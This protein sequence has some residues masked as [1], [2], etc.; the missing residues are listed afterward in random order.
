MKNKIFITF[1]FLLSFACKKENNT[2]KKT[3]ELD[4]AKI[5]G[6]SNKSIS[7]S[8]SITKSDIDP[9]NLKLLNS[10]DD[11][12]AEDDGVFKNCDEL[13]TKDGSNIFFLIIP[14]IGANIWYQNISKKLKGEIYEINDQ[15]S[16]LVLNKKN[17][18]TKEFD[19][20]AFYI[21]KKFTKKVNLDTPYTSIS[22]RQTLL[23]K[24]VSSNEQWEVVESFNVE[25]EKDE[26]K[27][28]YWRNKTIEDLINKSNS[29]QN[30]TSISSSWV[31]KYFVYFDYGNINSQNT[32]WE[33]VIDINRSNITAKG[34]GF[35]IGFE[36]QLY[37]F[38]IS[39]NEIQLKHKKNISGY[40]LGKK[41]N[42][43][44]TLKKIE[45][46]FYVDSKWISLDVK[47]KKSKDGY[48]I[49][50]ELN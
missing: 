47:N 44:F 31:G 6:I 12:C 34:D 3:L 13:Y 20:W 2:E 22:P 11:I 1:L 41:M 50:K 14:K 29:K 9:R 43:E 38:E 18:L 16:K 37:M 46:K 30:A 33:L 23:L 35:Q 17:D 19:V 39:Q 10:L 48:L 25:N 45:N 28:V 15:L 5:V 26:T 8:K 42:P 27:E 24:L 21:D 7:D 36:D 49:E 4:S 40:K 32:G